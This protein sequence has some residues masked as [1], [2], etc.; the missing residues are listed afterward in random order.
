MAK[1]Y[2][3]T[4]LEKFYF[5]QEILTSIIA[6]KI[7]GW[8][9]GLDT[10]PPE[11]IMLKNKYINWYN[12]A[13][14]PETRTKAAIAERQQSQK[15]YT[16][17]LRE[18]LKQYILFNKTV[19]VSDREAMGLKVYD[20]VRTPT[21]KPTTMPAGEVDF[22]IRRRHTI[23]VKDS[24]HTG[25]G[26]PPHVHGFETWY[27]IGSPPPTQSADFA[28][29]GFSS[30]RLFEINY[31]LEMV[32]KTVYYIFRWVNSRNEPGP[33]SEGITEAVIG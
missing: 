3:P 18:F 2:V 6:Q 21:P 16:K 24:V 8:Q 11:I 14:N 30:T 10:L 27:K 4:Q 15:D 26:L 19:P 5:W 9:T 22:S 20:T 12:Q 29:A 25:R 17:G 32:G 31:D 7:G 23:R 28:Y 13:N 1:D 33:W